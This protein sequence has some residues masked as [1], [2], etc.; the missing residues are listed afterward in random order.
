MFKLFFSPQPLLLALL[1]HRAKQIVANDADLYGM[2]L[3]GDG[4]TIQGMPLMNVLVTT[5]NACSVL[6]II[7]C[8]EHMEEGGKKDAKYI[9][10]IFCQ[11]IDELDPKGVHL[12]AVLFDGAS[13]VQKAG[14]VIEAKYTPRFL[15]FMGLN[16]SSLSFLPM[17][18]DCHSCSFSSSTISSPLQSLWLWFHARSVC[19]FSEA[20]YYIQWR[21]QVGFDSC[22]RQSYGRI[23]Y[24]L[25]QNA[26]IETRP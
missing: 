18:P 14:R 15:C 25:S 2:C 20:S 24:C 11:H 19:D 22:C 12:N 16:M 17:L 1:I 5:P 8:T 3:L 23:L 10:E 21:G 6:D 26:A 9:A 13:N 4:A 7:D